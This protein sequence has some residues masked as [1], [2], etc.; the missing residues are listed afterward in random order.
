MHYGGAGALGPPINGQ[1]LRVIAA[2]GIGGAGR[3]EVAGSAPS[4]AGS[5]HT[6]DDPL[7][8]EFPPRPGQE[9]QPPADPPLIRVRFAMLPCAHV[10]FSLRLISNMAM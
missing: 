5:A 9:S 10:S 3:E 1:L 4:G 7:Y 6:A 8:L 2:S